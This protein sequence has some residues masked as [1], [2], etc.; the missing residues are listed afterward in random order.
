MHALTRVPQT[1]PTAATVSSSLFVSLYW[2]ITSCLRHKAQ[3][4]YAKASVE[5]AEFESLKLVKVDAT[6]NSILAREHQIQSYPTLK[7]FVNGT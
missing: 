1:P 7:F 2:R 6:V 4:E 5:L 3:P